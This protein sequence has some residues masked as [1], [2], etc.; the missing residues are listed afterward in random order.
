MSLRQASL[1]KTKTFTCHSS[2][3][4][5]TTVA[6]FVLSLYQKHQQGERGT[7]AELSWNDLAAKLRGGSSGSSRGP[8]K[9][10]ADDDDINNIDTS[11]ISR[12]PPPEKRRND[13]RKDPIRGWVQRGKD[14]EGRG[15][16]NGKWYCW[17]EATF[18]TVRSLLTQ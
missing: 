13:Q 11:D 10:E 15:G 2:A 16:V 14:S 18:D 7:M 8:V 6:L 12:F 4:F 1:F 3:T 5:L 17:S 9:R